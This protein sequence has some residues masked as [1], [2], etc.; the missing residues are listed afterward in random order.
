MKIRCSWCK[1]DLGEKAPYEDNRVSHGICA[2][3]RTNLMKGMRH[4]PLDEHHT[5]DRER[6]VG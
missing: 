2:A 1:K 3:C 6:A 4:E 5:E